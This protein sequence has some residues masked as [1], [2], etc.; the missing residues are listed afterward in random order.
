[1]AFSMLIRPTGVMLRSL[2]V[3]IA[4]AVLACGPKALAS[5]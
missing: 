4:K 1:M 2:G 5:Q 3:T